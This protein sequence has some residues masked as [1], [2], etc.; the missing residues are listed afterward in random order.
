[1]FLGRPLRPRDASVCPLD[2]VGLISVMLNLALLWLG[3]ALPTQAEER[4]TIIV[5]KT[6]TQR[7]LS[8]EQLARI[9]LRKARFWN[10]ESQPFR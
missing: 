4:I 5:A 7:T 3:I 9:Y 8:N 1:M 6:A 10:D 2:I